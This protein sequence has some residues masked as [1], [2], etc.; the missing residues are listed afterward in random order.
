MQQQFN[1]LMRSACKQIFFIFFLS[2]VVLVFNCLARET[3]DENP[4]RLDYHLDR[5]KRDPAPLTFSAAPV[6]TPAIQAYLQY[7]GLNFDDTRHYFGKFRSNGRNL[8]AHVFY[9]LHPIATVFILH[10]YC[11]HTGNLKHLIRLLLDMK[12][13]VAAFDLPGHGLSDGRTGSINDFDEYATALSDFVKS[14]RGHLP[15]TSFFIGHSTGCAVELE[16]MVRNLEFKFSKIIFLAPLVHSAYWTITKANYYLA[17]PFVETVPRIFRVNSSDPDFI[18]FIKTDPLQCRDIPLKWVSALIAWNERVQDYQPRLQSI[19]VV[20][21]TGDKVVDWRFNIPFLKRKFDAVK[22]NWIEDAR[23][24]LVNEA[25]AYR[26]IVFSHI[27]AYL[28]NN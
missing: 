5:L 7:Y 14:C 20:Q 11:D 26:S 15:T 24:Q 22:V 6:S 27:K 3:A 28:K 18:E 25:P 23:H 9:P 13:A 2:T 8:A 12:L 19:L 17:K 10:G 16:L 4:D 1:P 21:G